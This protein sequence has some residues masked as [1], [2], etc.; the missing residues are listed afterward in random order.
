MRKLLKTMKIISTIFHLS[1]E[2]GDEYESRY[3][4]DVEPIENYKISEFLQNNFV[5]ICEKNNFYKQKYNCVLVKKNIKEVDCG[6]VKHFF[7]YISK[8]NQ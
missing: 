4:G 7:Y 5:K 2:L 1:T 6:Y 8:K 3:D